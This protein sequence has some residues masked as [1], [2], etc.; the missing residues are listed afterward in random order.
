MAGLFDE[1]R[2]SYAAAAEASLGNLR[3]EIKVG[4]GRA[5][6]EYWAADGSGDAAAKATAET[7]RLTAEAEAAGQDDLMLISTHNLAEMRAG[8]RALRPYEI[9]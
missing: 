1:A 4:L 5:L 3:G 9:L 8:G 6:L 7:E 2:Q